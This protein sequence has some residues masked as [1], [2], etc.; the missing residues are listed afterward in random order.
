MRLDKILSVRQLRAA[1]IAKVIFHLLVFITLV[2]ATWVAPAIAQTDEGSDEEDILTVGSQAPVLNIETW[3][4]DREGEFEHTTEFEPGKIYLIDFW[5]TWSLVSHPWMA[6]Y[7][8][9]QDHYFDDGLQIIRVSDEDED[10]VGNFLELDVKG[11]VETIYAEWTLGYCVT[12]DPDRSV[13]EDYMAAAQQVKVPVVFIVGR[14]GLIEWIGDPS[15]MQEP[16]QQ[17]VVG[18]WDREA[19]RV[20]MLA[21]QK[22]QKMA[23]EVRQLVQQGNAEGALR[24]IEEMMPGTPDSQI[25]TEMAELRL[26]ILLANDG[27]NLAEAFKE[28]AQRRAED[29]YKLNEMA[30]GIVTRE[31]G[32]IKIAPDL[33]EIATETARRGV[34]LARKKGDQGQLVDDHLGAILD[35]YAHLVF[36]QGDLEKALEIQLEASEKSQRDDIFEYLD[37]LQSEKRKRE[38]NEAEGDEA[39][40]AEADEAAQEGATDGDNDEDSEPAAVESETENREIEAADPAGIET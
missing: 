30:W 23:G 27:P 29:S 28:V 37:V 4:S 22:M 36:L 9:L 14:T 11:D 18:Q 1:A 39:D 26:E 10:S 12:T 38:S 20:K 35:T 15:M 19:F 31:Q 16:L 33:L 32:G 8:S 17:I 7:A 24:L 6:K 3:F 13:H 5:A 2:A 34:E 40:E 21:T 25:R